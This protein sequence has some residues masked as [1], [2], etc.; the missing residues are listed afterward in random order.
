MF[1]TNK[2]FVFILHTLI[3]V[4][5]SAYG[6]LGPNELNDRQEYGYAV[7]LD[8]FKATHQINTLTYRMK[9]TER[10]EG[11]MVSQESVVKLQRNPYRVY[12]MQV[13]PKKG[14]EVL[15]PENLGDEHALIN[16][17]GFPWVN[18]RL[19]PHGSIMRKK[20]HHT[21]LDAG[22]AHVVSILETLFAKYGKET[23]DMITASEPVKWTG[24][25][26]WK[27]VFENPQF[28][29]ID[30]TVKEGETIHS[31][32]RERKISEYM[33]LENN[34]ECSDFDD[35]N[36]GQVIR[37][38]NDYSPKMELIIEQKRNL[39]LLMKI[40]DHKGIFELYEFGE[41]VVNPKIPEEEFSK[42]FED[43]GF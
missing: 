21:I 5:F 12:T 20:Q 13:S 3:L 15:Y 40:Y 4:A 1:S 28:E 9:K 33:V 19:D 31:L 10:I 43:Y 25:D 14:L 16:P 36:A 23:P 2:S 11:K 22:Y 35:V 41:L 24:V 29:F 18:V 32:A 42:D 39:P 26:C 27:I 7:A 37:I 30:Y 34:K 8:M 38:P 6:Q 17:N